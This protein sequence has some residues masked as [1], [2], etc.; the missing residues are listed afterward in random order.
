[1]LICEL[2]LDVIIKIIP[3]NNPSG[4]RLLKHIKDYCDYEIKLENFI[5]KR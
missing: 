3:K 1:M 5:I 2:L 4:I